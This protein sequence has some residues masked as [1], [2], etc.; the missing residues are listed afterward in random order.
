MNRLAVFLIAALLGFV[1][2]FGVTRTMKQKPALLDSMP[3]LV[4][5]EKE[6][7]LQGDALKQAAELHR[8]YRP[9][10]EALCA[11]IL[12]ARE[13]VKTAAEASPGKLSPDLSTALEEQ[14]RVHAECQKAMIAH[15]YETAAVMPPEQAERY[16]KATL[17][18]ALSLSSYETL[19]VH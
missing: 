4:W 13:A 2:A 3:E 17:P 18:H 6:L 10:C 12:R 16:L 8:S 1:V 15:L 19:T 9:R 14:A 7:G 5:L 11:E